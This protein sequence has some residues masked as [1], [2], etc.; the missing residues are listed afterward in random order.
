MPLQYESGRDK[1]LETC[2]E[3][4]TCPKAAT[5]MTVPIALSLHEDTT[6]ASTASGFFGLVCIP[7]CYLHAE[8]GSATPLWPEPFGAWGQREDRRQGN[9]KGRFRDECGSWDDVVRRDVILAGN[10]LNLRDRSTWGGGSS[11]S[12]ACKR[13]IVGIVSDVS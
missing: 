10:L 2:S 12:Q 8:I 7:E 9:R 5:S 1:A 4:E 13:P 6:L 3:S 11:S